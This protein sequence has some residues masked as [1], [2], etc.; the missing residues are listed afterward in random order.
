MSEARR[1]S[2]VAMHAELARALGSGALKFVRLV[3]C[4]NANVIRAKAVHASV[5]GHYLD[6]GV[7]ITVGQQALPVLYD[8]VIPETGL[9]PVGEARLIPDWPTLTPLPHA[10]GQARA[11]AD[12]HL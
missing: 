6:E 1:L 11:L 5:L 7:G 3:W 9:G 8:A 10:P 12:M 4:D 2:G